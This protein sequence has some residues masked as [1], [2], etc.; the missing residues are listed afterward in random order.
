MESW[1]PLRPEARSIGDARR[2]THR[3]LDGW[4]LEHLSDNAALLVSEVATN[5]LL[6]D[7]GP[8]QLRLCASDAELRIEVHDTSPELPRRRS[9]SATATTGRGLMLLEELAA[10]WGAEPTPA[11]KQVW[12]TLPVRSPLADAEE[13]RL[14]A[15][16]A[17]DAL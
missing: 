14:L 17:V 9:F 15:L 16:D 8:A 4:C 6:H 5:A 12:F 2:F 10:A 11:G 3:T 13:S 1:I 7:S